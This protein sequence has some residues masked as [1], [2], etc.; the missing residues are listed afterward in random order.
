M[1]CRCFSSSATRGSALGL[2]YTNPNRCRSFRQP[3]WEYCTLNFVS[4]K[5]ITGRVSRIK[6]ASS[7]LHKAV[8]WVALRKVNPP[9]QSNVVNR[10]S[11]RSIVLVPDSNRVV[12]EIKRLANSRATPAITQ[13]QNRV[14]APR[15]AVI[16]RRTAHDPLKFGPL[17]GAEKIRFDHARIRIR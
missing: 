3:E 7:Q 17:V 1:N 6:Y 11:P 5:A 15:N 10:S 13:Q 8:F 12:I 2:R 4:I 16:L 9:F 14:G